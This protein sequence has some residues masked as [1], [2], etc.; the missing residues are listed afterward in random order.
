M[1][2]GSSGSSVAVVVV[3]GPG[4]VTTIITHGG[5]RGGGRHYAVPLE[6]LSKD[7]ALHRQLCRDCG[8]RRAGRK[9]VWA[10]LTK[11][12]KYLVNLQAKLIKLLLICIDNLAK[13]S[14]TDTFT[15]S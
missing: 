4:G 2:A 1:L 15:I 14:V 13:K 6:R 8:A 5:C 11:V 9:L 3:A 10:F 7:L 12:A